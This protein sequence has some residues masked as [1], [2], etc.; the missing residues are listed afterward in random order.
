MVNIDTAMVFAAG[1]GTRMRPLTNDIPKPMVEVCGKPLIDYRLD[2]LAAAGV[3]KVIVNTHYKADIIEA[4]LKQRHDMEIIFSYEETLLETGGGIVKALPHFN[5]QPFYLI[6]GDVIW[7]DETVPALLRLAEA[8]TDNMNELLLLQPTNQAIGYKGEGDFD[9]AQ[10]SLLKRADA[11]PRDYVFTG[12]Q[13]FHPHHIEG[14]KEEPFSRSILWKEAT[15]TDGII[16]HVHG[17][18]HTG[19]WLHIDSPEALIEAEAFLNEETDNM[20]RGVS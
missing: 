5:N 15:N 20:L 2:K 19:G 4:Y 1:L 6:N 3:K 12:I 8:W 17:L 9:L 7:L 10:D 11:T 18:V 13:I 16:Q 14:Y